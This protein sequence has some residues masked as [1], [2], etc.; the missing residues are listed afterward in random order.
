MSLDIKTES[1]IRRNFHEQRLFW[2]LNHPTN[3]LLLHIAD[4]IF[5]LLNV[6]NDL[7]KKE[8]RKALDI[9]E[10]FTSVSFPILPGVAKSLGLL[11]A[12]PFI[13][14]LGG[15]E[16]APGDLINRY[17]QFY[18]KNPDLVLL[19]KSIIKAQN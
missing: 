18:K 13:F 16:I 8:H 19:N 3:A 2:T 4:Q 17:F 11:F 7:Q 12:D 5:S 10:L 14:R 9:P 6:K 15:Q 1:F